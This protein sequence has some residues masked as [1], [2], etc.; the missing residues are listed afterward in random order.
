MIASH[1][2]FEVA[3]LNENV[4]VRK[5]WLANLPTL[6]LGIFAGGLIT[7]G[8]RLY[9]VSITGLEGGLGAVRLLVGLVF[10]LGLVLVIVRG[11]EIFRGRWLIVIM[12]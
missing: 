9:S 10:L 7:F 2:L 8:A 4:G 11:L 6:M 3:K 12:K 1:T 5:A